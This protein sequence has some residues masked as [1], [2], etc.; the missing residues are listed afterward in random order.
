MPHSRPSWAALQRIGRTADE[1]RV[2][3][4]VTRGRGK[5]YFGIVRVYLIAVAA[6]W[7]A[8]LAAGQAGASSS[9][10]YTYDLN[11]NL[12]VDSRSQS[13][14]SDGTSYH[15]QTLETIN[16]RSRP[17]EEVVERV[18]QSGPGVRVIERTI[19]RYDQNGNPGAPEK[20]A[21]EERHAPDGTVTT[22][23][24]VYRGD[25]NGNMVL[26]ERSTS[27]ERKS[28][29]QISCSDHRGAAHPQWRPGGGGAQ[30]YDR[31]RN[32]QPHAKKTKPP[33]GPTSAAISFR[34]PA[35]CP[36]RYRK[37]TTPRKP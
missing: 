10:T 19:R 25:L 11:G 9:T 8:P 33:I 32:G 34:L 14:R 3:V 23:T 31:H 4:R 20:Q 29:S 7:L 15:E 13:G 1:F 24:T 22:S 36:A 35:R 6:I 30:E 16:G 37:A 12:V 2:T 17:T 28:G 18:V 26:A 21:I 5:V 27:E